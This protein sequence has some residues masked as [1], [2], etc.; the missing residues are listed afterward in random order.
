MNYKRVNQ[1]VTP[2]ENLIDLDELENEMK[3]RE[4][5]FDSVSSKIKNT[6]SRGGMTGYEQVYSPQMFI[7][8]EPV[9][10]KIEES[11]PMIEHPIPQYVPVPVNTPLSP[12]QIS[13]LTVSEHITLCPICPRIYNQN[14]NTHV[15]IIVVLIVI[16]IVLLKKVIESK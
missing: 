10:V 14:N 8:Q 1:K 3:D 7:K 15:L 11:R 2:I 5:A 13:C 16:C 9:Q 12:E 4:N 6:G